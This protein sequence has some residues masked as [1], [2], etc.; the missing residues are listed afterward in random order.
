MVRRAAEHPNKK[1][2][3]ATLGPRATCRSA[4]EVR[5]YQHESWPKEARDCA[6]N[7]YVVER[8][9]GVRK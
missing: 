8:W 2:R 6:A 4:N 7:P 1:N 5:A 3:D 9:L